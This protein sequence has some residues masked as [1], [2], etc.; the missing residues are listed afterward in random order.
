MNIDT[1]MY[2]KGY[3]YRLIPRDKSFEPLYAKTIKDCTMIKTELYR[4]KKFFVKCIS[5]KN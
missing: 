4:D 2:A 5:P 1:A 3:R